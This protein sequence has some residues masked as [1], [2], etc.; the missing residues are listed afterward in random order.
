LYLVYSMRSGEIRSKPPRK[1]E[2]VKEG[3]AT[4][5]LENKLRS[6]DGNKREDGKTDGAGSSVRQ[7]ERRQLGRRRPL[8]AAA[9]AA[10]MERASQ[11]TAAQPGQRPPSPASPEPPP[12]A[13]ASPEP[14]PLAHHIQQE[15]LRG[16][17]AAATLAF[18]AAAAAPE[19][20]GVDSA[21]R[22]AVSRGETAHSFGMAAAREVRDTAGAEAV[23]ATIELTAEPRLDEAAA[24]GAVGAADQAAGGGLDAGGAPEAVP[25]QTKFTPTG[26]ES[27]DQAERDALAEPWSAATVAAMASNLA[28][29]YLHQICSV[30]GRTTTETVHDQAACGTIIE[31]RDMLDICFMVEVMDVLVGTGHAASTPVLLILAV[32]AWWHSRLTGGPTEDALCHGSAMD[33]AA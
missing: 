23:A 29:V 7:T 27:A 21:A 14:P 19:D 1:I 16:V 9:L 13:P 3:R 28:P 12:L 33:G 30:G 32:A 15:Q 2:L 17:Y 4:A 22:A 11:P 26:G 6:R 10:E 8:P 18:Q 5:A 25:G 31:V 20:E 24:G